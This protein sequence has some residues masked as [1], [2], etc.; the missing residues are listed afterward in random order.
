MAQAGTG[1]CSC[2]GFS[3]CGLGGGGAAGTFE[4]VLV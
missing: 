1:V 2:R 4:M 3:P